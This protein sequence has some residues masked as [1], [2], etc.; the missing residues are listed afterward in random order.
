[1]RERGQCL[2]VAGVIDPGRAEEIADKLEELAREAQPTMPAYG[3]PQSLAAL[4]RAR[5]K[6]FGGACVLDVPVPA[7]TIDEAALDVP[8][9]FYGAYHVPFFATWSLCE[10]AALRAAKGDRAGAAA[11]LQPVANRAAG[12]TWLVKALQRYR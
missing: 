4:V 2:F 7:P 12:R 10:R 6:F 8:L 9:D 5:A 11:L 3:I 1:M